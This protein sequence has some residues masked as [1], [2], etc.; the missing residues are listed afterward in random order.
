MNETIVKLKCLPMS[1]NNIDSRKMMLIHQ[2][3]DLQDE[4]LL[5]Q[6]EV[7]FKKIK[8]EDGVLNQLVRPR[9]KKLDV[10]ELIKEQKFKGVDRKKF[11]MLIKEINIKEP[12]E[13]L[14]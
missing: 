14:L 6:L 2:I 4:S 1:N 5:G 7:A 10:E 13:V 12:V 3:T 8:G 11:D 9:R